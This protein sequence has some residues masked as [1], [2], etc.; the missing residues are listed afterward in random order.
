MGSENDDDGELVVVVVIVLLALDIS[1]GTSGTESCSHLRVVVF[2]HMSSH[3]AVRV[4]I[5]VLS[6][7]SSLEAMSPFAGPTT[8]PTTVTYRCASI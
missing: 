5:L 1:T 2:R 8:A 6:T 7:I 3:L 4:E